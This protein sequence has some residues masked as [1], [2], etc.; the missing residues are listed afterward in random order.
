M[1][2]ANAHA[3]AAR[4]RRRPSV[5]SDSAVGA[6][7][8]ESSGSPR[9]SSGVADGSVGRDVGEDSCCGTESNATGL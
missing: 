8:A 1:R 4:A 7:V 3:A 5:P 6:A 9:G 2:A